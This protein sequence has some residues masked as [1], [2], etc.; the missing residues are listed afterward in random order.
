MC[1]RAILAAKNR[2]VDR[3]ND[4]ASAYFPG[5]TKIYLSAD[6]VLDDIQKN[7]YP[8]EILNQIR[9][10][11]MPQHRLCLKINQPIIL[12]RNIAQSQGLCNG[13][14]MIIR[15][16][17]RTFLDVEIA[18]GK[19]KGKRFF[20]PRLGITPSDSDYPVSIKRVQF[21]IRSAF[22]MTINKSQGATL[23]KVG[24]YLNDPVFSHGQLYV[25]MSRVASLSDITVATNSIIEGITRNVVYKEIFTN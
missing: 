19:N 12:L 21:P 15:G 2:D 11:S 8:T 3:I 5:E 16:M 10:S 13:T 25:A 7:I 14:R 9:D 23:K 20:I 18:L 6:S 1:T 24:I 22:A 17:H 4:I